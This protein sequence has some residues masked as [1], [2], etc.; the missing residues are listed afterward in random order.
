[1]QQ[2]KVKFSRIHLTANFSKWSFVLYTLHSSIIFSPHLGI[3]PPPND[4][5]TNVSNNSLSISWIAP[6]SLQ[7]STPPT[8]SQYVLSNN[9]TNGTKTFNN[10]TTC[11]P[12][13]S[14]NYSLDLRD[15]FFKT[16]GNGNATMLDYNGVVEFTLFAVNGA[17]NGNA[18]TRTLD[19]QRRS[20]TG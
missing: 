1:M 3:L 16:D 2:N 15:P 11:N 19:L 18:T 20:P 14:C 17:G 8:I 6:D 9:L 5:K 4:L 10:P 12:L 13:T 7:V